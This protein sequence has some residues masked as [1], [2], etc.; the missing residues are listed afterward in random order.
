M[1]DWSCS[2]FS[3][4]ARWQFTQPI[5]KC[6]RYKHNKMQRER[7]RREKKLEMKCNARAEKSAIITIQLSIQFFW[8][9]FLVNVWCHISWVQKTITAMAVCI[10]VRAQR[11]KC[12]IKNAVRNDR[13]DFRIMIIWCSNCSMR[14]IDLIDKEALD[15]RYFEFNVAKD[16]AFDFFFFADRNSETMPF[17]HMKTEKWHEFL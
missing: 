9:L 12:S 13:I 14:L 6:F 1:I 5:R 3:L 11:E 8:K 4:S 16:F 2:H 7:Q 15:F 10:C 17:L